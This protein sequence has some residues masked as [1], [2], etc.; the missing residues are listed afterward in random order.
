MQTQC[1]RRAWLSWGSW[2]RLRLSNW[3]PIC[4]SKGGHNSPFSTTCHSL[5]CCTENEASCDKKIISS[6]SLRWAWLPDLSSIFSQRFLL[7]GSILWVILLHCILRQY[8]KICWGTMVK[9]RPMDTVE[10][11]LG[12]DAGTCTLDHRC[13]ATV[14]LP[15]VGEWVLFYRDIQ[16]FVKLRSQCLSQLFPRWSTKSLCKTRKW[17]SIFWINLLAFLWGMCSTYSL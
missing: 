5:L 4:L 2:M 6:Q 10:E 7:Q 14:P 17:T 9:I 1:L 11:V 15:K 3:A 12:F 8:L 13:K 16:Y